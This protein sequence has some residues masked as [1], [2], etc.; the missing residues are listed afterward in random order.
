MQTDQ[1]PTTSA[2]PAYN[3]K[4]K[5][6]QVAAVATYVRN[7]WGN[8]APPVDPEQVRD[9]RKKLKKDRGHPS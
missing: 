8:H 9:M 7:A 4:L 3:W 5:D 2:M 1:R 6:D